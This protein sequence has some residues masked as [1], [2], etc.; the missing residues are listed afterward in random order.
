MCLYL[1]LLDREPKYLLQSNCLVVKKQR[2]IDQNDLMQLQKLQ[3]QVAYT[4]LLKVMSAYEDRLIA[5]STDM[6]LKLKKPMVRA[7]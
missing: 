2:L 4:K 7:G 1:L 6:M 5:F 3:L